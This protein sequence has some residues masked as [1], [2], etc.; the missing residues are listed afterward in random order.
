VLYAANQCLAAAGATDAGY[1]AEV[2]SP[3]PTVRAWT[4]LRLVA[5][6]SFRNVRGPID[7]LIVTGVDGPEDAR[8]YPDLVR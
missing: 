5:D 2:V 4:G 3:V 7:T 8:R 6:R 1:V